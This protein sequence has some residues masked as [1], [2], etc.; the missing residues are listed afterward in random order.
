MLGFAGRN[1]AGDNKGKGSE[2]A[3]STPPLVQCNVES[4]LPHGHVDAEALVTKLPHDMQ[5]LLCIV[6]GIESVTTLKRGC[7]SKYVM[8]RGDKEGV[9]STAKRTFKVS[10][11]ATLCR[12]QAC[13][14][15]STTT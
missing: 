7:R 8:F 1:A 10:S 11:L 13:Y 6:E 15:A 9:E 5:C 14:I 3:V 4:S 2:R 12:T